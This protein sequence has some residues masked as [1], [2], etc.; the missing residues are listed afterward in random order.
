MSKFVYEADDVELADCQCDLCVYRLE[1]RP[2]RCEKYPEKP[3][4]ILND[5]KK[6]PYMRTPDYIDL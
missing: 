5:E 6:C 4:E 3:R 1:G 2:G